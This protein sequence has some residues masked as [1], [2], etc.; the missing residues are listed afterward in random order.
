MNTIHSVEIRGNRRKYPSGKLLGVTTRGR[1]LGCHLFYIDS[2][3]NAVRLGFPSLQSYLNLV[4]F[5]LI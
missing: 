4:F 1:I 2:Q 5:C 3:E